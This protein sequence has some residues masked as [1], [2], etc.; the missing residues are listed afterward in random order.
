VNT[1]SVAARSGEGARRGLPIDAVRRQHAA[2]RRDGQGPGAD[3]AVPAGAR[4]R[5][6]C[7]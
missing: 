2:A 4:R 3:G 7:R 5:S 1:R 6:E